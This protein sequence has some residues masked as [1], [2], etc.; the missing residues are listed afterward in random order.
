MGN[1]EGFMEVVSLEVGLGGHVGILWLRLGMGA[2]AQMG[3][4]GL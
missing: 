3:A 1:R 4:G 2:Y